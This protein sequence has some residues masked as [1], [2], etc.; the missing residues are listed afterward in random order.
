MSEEAICSVGPGITRDKEQK[1]PERADCLGVRLL[2]PPTIHRSPR[3]DRVRREVKSEFKDIPLTLPSPQR[4]E[5]IY[6]GN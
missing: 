4:G 2:R 6:L 5:G 1:Q 3:N